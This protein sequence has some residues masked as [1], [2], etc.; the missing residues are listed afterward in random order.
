MISKSTLV[1]LLASFVAL[2]Q[3]MMP[4]PTSPLF[5][6]KTQAELQAREENIKIYLRVEL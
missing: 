6:G 1:V 4:R 2:S 3:A 5:H